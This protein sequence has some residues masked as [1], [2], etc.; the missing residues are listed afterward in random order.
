[1]NHVKLIYYCFDHR[2]LAIFVEPVESHP[3]GMVSI[4]ELREACLS[5]DEDIRITALQYLVSDAR[6]TAMPP[7]DEMKLL[8]QVSCWS[9]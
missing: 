1:V 4:E 9:I 8:V 6:S 5:G 7:S 2:A 3:S